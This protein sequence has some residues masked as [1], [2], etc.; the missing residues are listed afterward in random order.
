MYFKI[1]RNTKLKKLQGAYATKVGKDINTFR[2]VWYLWIQLCPFST[3]SAFSPRFLYD[4]NRINEE[5]TPATL[6][7]ENDDT[8][9]VM[10][11]RELIIPLEFGYDAEF[12][13]FG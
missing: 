12:A 1:K 13:C 10:V 2:Y 7:M 8:I 5:D 6:D 11:E 4:G 3:L 9:D